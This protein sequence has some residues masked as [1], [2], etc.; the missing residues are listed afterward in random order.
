[1]VTTEA[2]SL[3]IIPRWIWIRARDVGLFFDIQRW[4]EIQITQMAVDIDKYLTD[5]KDCAI[6]SENSKRRKNGK[7]ALAW[8]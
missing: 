8:R 2:F 7:S 4:K 5:D 1:M 3:R 6:L